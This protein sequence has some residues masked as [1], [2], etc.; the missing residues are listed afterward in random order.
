M[1][2]Q[3]IFKLVARILAAYLGTDR[4][5]QIKIIM[6]DAGF[7][8]TSSYDCIVLNHCIAHRLRTYVF[9]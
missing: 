1:L 6:K 2:I 5:S 4:G 9:C 8:V 3:Q 7:V